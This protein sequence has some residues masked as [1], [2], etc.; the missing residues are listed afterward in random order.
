MPAL[1]NFVTDKQAFFPFAFVEEELEVV[2]QQFDV[3]RV[4][5]I[6]TSRSRKTTMTSNERYETS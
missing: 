4:P 1:S 5:R 2:D 6:Q 3:K